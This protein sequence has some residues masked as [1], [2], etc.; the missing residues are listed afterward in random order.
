MLR[1]LS[2]GRVEHPAP[3]VGTPPFL[4]SPKK[5]SKKGLP[6]QGSLTQ[7][8][9]TINPEKAIDFLL[10]AEMTSNSGTSSCFCPQH[11]SLYACGKNSPGVPDFIAISTLITKSHCIFWVNMYQDLK[12]SRIF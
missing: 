5:G 10:R 9:T 6:N 4:Q 2:T 12:R 7:C 1:D 3:L 8:L 11:I